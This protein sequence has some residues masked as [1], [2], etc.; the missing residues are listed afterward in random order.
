MSVTDLARRLVERRSR[1]PVVSLYLDLDPEEFATPPARETQVH[2]LIDGAKPDVEAD[3]SL[4][5]EDKIAL[6]EDLERVREYLLSDEPPF[7]GAHGLGVFASKLDDLFEVVQLPQPVEGRVVIGR[8]PY[9]EPLV[10]AVQTERWCAALVSRDRGRVLTGSPSN[11]RER[12]RITDDVHGRVKKGGWSQS[13]YE[14]SADQDAEAHLRRI[15]DEIYR[16]WR[17]EGF[18]HLAVGGPEQDVDRFAQLVHNDLRARLVAT[19]LAV[20]ESSATDDDIRIALA[21]LV[22]EE[23]RRHE[24]EALDLLAERLGQGERAAGGPEAT[25]GALNERRV[26]TLLLERRAAR[27]GGRCPS[28]GMLTLQ[29]DGECPA[30]GTALEPVEDLAEAAIEAAVLQDAEVLVVERYPDLG[31]HQGFAALLRY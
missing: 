4:D 24:R 13:N 3:E 19:R 7:Q 11:L 5:H 12:E 6:R 8:G 18:D 14:R 22:D 2:S 30:D 20:D 26:E 16:L 17:R 9:I 29:S 1:H 23:N 15:A 21:E 31:P 25:L 10:Q 27:R 28:D